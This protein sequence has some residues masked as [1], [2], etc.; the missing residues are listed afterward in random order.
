MSKPPAPT[1]A[2]LTAYAEALDAAARYIRELR[3]DP[4]SCPA[5]D[6]VRTERTYR[7]KLAALQK[8]RPQR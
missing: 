5:P 4:H 8:L 7:E 1:D 3:A 6:V 2:L